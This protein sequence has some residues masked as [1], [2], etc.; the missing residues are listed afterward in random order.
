MVFFCRFLLNMHPRLTKKKTGQRTIINKS[1]YF[2]P[3]RAHCNKTETRNEV[4]DV[5][6]YLLSS[7]Y[8]DLVLFLVGKW[9]FQ[10]PS[11]ENVFR[12][13]AL[14]VPFRNFQRKHVRRYNEA[15]R[16]K[17]P[18]ASTGF[19]PSQREKQFLFLAIWKERVAKPKSLLF[20]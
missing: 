14:L 20:S 11:E 9:N 17:R 1:E 3:S 7:T 2:F 4:H 19:I 15:K 5:K 18:A 10:L 8:I 12:P 13:Q 16:E 6:T